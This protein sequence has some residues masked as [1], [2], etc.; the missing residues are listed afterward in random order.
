MPL[1]T[2]GGIFNGGV[3]TDRII[4][5]GNTDFQLTNTLLQAP[6]VGSYTLAGV[7]EAYLTDT[8]SGHTFEVSGCRGYLLASTVRRPRMG[9]RAA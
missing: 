3:G 6:G 2:G 5:S 7:A 9:E 8:G 4:E 1:E